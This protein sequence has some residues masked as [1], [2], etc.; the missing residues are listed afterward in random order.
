MPK[1]RRAA[2]LIAN[3]AHH[4]LF[5]EP[6]PGF[7]VLQSLSIWQAEEA[8]ANLPLRL[9]VRMHCGYQV[10]VGRTLDNQA[11]LHGYF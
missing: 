11:A 10:L 5:P 4:D 1:T 3:A 9:A 7:A 6:S 2:R 8:V